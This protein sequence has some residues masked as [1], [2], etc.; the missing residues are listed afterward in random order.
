MNKKYDMETAPLKKY[1]DKWCSG[2]FDCHKY[3]QNCL[4]TFFCHHCQT[5]RQYNKLK[6]NN[7]N[8]NYELH[9]FLFWIFLL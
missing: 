6:Y 4:E 7:Q 5:S 9:S 8:V 2:L 3:M 1:Y